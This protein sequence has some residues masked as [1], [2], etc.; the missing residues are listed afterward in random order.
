M[1]QA[2][3]RARHPAVC[4]KRLLPSTWWSVR[5]NVY[6]YLIILS[7]QEEKGSEQ[8]TVRA[9]P[10]RTTKGLNSD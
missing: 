9:V 7:L 3:S 4:K 10:L 6:G 8:K 1:E 5:I 2:A